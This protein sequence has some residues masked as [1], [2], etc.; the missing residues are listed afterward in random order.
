MFRFID[1]DSSYRWVTV[2]IDYFSDV[3]N[4]FDIREYAKR[5][6]NSDADEMLLLIEEEEL[7]SGANHS[8]PI[9]RKTWRAKDSKDVLVHQLYFVDR[10]Y[11]Y[12][13]TSTFTPPGP[14][15]TD[16][17]VEIVRMENEYRKKLLLEI[18]STV[19]FKGRR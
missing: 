15:T 6:F 16:Q 7:F 4:D 2:T 13:F 17:H 18:A 8:M 12:C 11:G 9:L 14:C 3:S 19:R 10:K 1:V 5:Y